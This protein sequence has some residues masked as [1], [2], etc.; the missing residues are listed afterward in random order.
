LCVGT[1]AITHLSTMHELGA[2]VVLATD[3][4]MNFWEGGLWSADTDVP[5]LIV[6][7]ATSEKPGMMAMATHLASLFGVPA[8]YVDVAYPYRV[9]V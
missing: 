6:N 9:V 8:E 7:H 4:G 1:G 5:V 2:D 3:D